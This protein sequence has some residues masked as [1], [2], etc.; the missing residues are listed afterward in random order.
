MT[1]PAAPSNPR[2]PFG[3]HRV[4]SAGE[5]IS[6]CLPIASPIATPLRQPNTRSAVVGVT[7]LTLKH[8]VVP[9]QF[10]LTADVYVATG[11]TIARA[12]PARISGRRVHLWWRDSLRRGAASL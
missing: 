1:S 12:A 9:Q 8:P 3:Y 6:V 10:R 5:S 2:T 11:L 4:M 7:S